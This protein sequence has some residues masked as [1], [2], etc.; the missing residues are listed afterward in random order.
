[1]KMFAK[2][3]LLV[4]LSSIVF[5]CATGDLDK[6]L[7]P[8]D[9]FNTTFLEYLDNP[10]EKVMVVAVD[11]GGNWACGYAYN[12]SS[13]KIAAQKAA[14]QCDKSREKN[15]VHTKAKLFAVNNDIVY[16]DNQ[17]K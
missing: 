11:L 14:T 2:W 8:P 4:V 13:T 12:W 3:V 17:F 7:P 5:G 9:A 6:R 15:I 16:Y 10:G 1:M